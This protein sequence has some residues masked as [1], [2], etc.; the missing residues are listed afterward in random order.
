MNIFSILPAFVV[1]FG[2]ALIPLNLW[3][4][5]YRLSMSGAERATLDRDMRADTRIW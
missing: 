2:M 1:I 3:Y 5:R 4:G